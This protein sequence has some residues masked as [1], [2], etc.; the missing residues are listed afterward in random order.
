LHEEI[1]HLVLKVQMKLGNSNMVSQSISEILLVIS[2]HFG[3]GLALV[4]K[5]LSEQAETDVKPQVSVLLNEIRNL[6]TIIK[7]VSSIYGRDKLLSQKMSMVSPISQNIGSRFVSR[8]D[9]LIGE[10]RQT[11]VPSTF[12]YVPILDT[13]RFVSKFISF[14]KSKKN[15]VPDHLN[16]YCNGD[17]YKNSEFFLEKPEWYSDSSVL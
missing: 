1:A 16:E 11:A 2:N 13:I 17:R 10:L 8:Y 9:K 4:L 14:E 6:P 5:K 3:Q 7:D 15:S 12:E